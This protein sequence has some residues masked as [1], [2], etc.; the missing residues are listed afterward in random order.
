MNSA[1]AI[2]NVSRGAHAPSR[3]GFG[4]LAE[5]AADR[6]DDLLSPISPTHL[7]TPHGTRL[8][9]EATR[10][11]S[12]AMDAARAPHPTR[13]GACAPLMPVSPAGW[14]RTAGD[15]RVSTATESH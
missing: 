5:V 12:A 2:A 13:E 4:A 11:D 7:N 14:V 3:V 9:A 15:F 1:T 6:P 10:K 8:R